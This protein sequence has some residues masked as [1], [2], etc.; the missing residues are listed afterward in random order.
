MRKKKKSRI[1]SGGA[2][3]YTKAQRK[4]H[5]ERFITKRNVLQNLRIQGKKK[6]LTFS[7]TFADLSY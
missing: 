6:Y 3:E 7:P 1:F 4:V 2:D 5:A